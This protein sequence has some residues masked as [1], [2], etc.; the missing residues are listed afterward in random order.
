MLSDPQNNMAKMQPQIEGKELLLHKI[1]LRLILT[2]HVFTVGRI[3]AKQVDVPTGRL[4]ESVAFS[5]DGNDPSH[6]LGAIVPHKFAVIKSIQV[7]EKP[8]KARST[9]LHKIQYRQAGLPQIRHAVTV[10]RSKP[11]IPQLE[12]KAHRLRSGR[13]GQ[14]RSNRSPRIRAA[15][16]DSVAGQQSCL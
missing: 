15:S 4:G 11:S 2:T 8:C 9:S 10:A 5:G 6:R 14:G 3:S 16:W 1:H 13:H 12:N 7:S